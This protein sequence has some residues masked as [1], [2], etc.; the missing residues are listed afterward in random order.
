[1]K[2]PPFQLS[3]FLNDDSFVRW[4]LNPEENTAWAYF[5]ELHPEQQTLVD[6]ARQV[7]LDIYSAEQ[8][9]ISDEPDKRAVWARIEAHTIGEP[10]VQSKPLFWQAYSYQFAA[11]VLVLVVVSII[12]ILPART[13]T[14]GYNDLIAKAV[15]QRME[16]INTTN[17]AQRIVLED[18]SIITLEKGAK[19]SYPAHFDSR[20]REVVLS[21]EAF[22]EITPDPGR[23]FYVYA[24]ELVTKV[25]GTSF[26]I[27]AFDYD[28]QVIVKV[29]TGRVSV[30]KQEHVEIND[31]ETGGLVL[32]PNQQAI[33]SRESALLNRRLVD[34]PQPV[35]PVATIS[36]KYFEETPVPVVLQALERVYGVSILYNADVLA[37]CYI[38]TTLSN[39]SLYD[40]LEVITQ[41]I[42]ATY[43]EIDAQIL[44]ESN[45]CR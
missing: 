26:R 1:M 13:K 39:E 17:A 31:P 45:G 37:G 30:F 23:P 33:F 15:T 36:R 9:P 10:A 38:T 40:Q 22:F 3:D 4:V 41:T 28:K 32:L 14:I 18:G 5:L 8:Q 16:K 42:G 27:S 11:V 24:N 29:H 6:Q 12:A 35:Q 19:L 2:H 7:I 34:E 25:L 43:K 21:G 20:R 44:I